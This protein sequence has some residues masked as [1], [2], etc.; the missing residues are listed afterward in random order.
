M[1]TTLSVNIAAWP[2]G[3]SIPA[4]YAF[5]KIPAAGH[6]ELGGNCS[7]AIAW[8]GA[9]DNTRSFAIICHDPD[10]PSVADDVNQEGKT[11][12]SDLPRVDFYHWV[13]VDIPADMA[14]LAEGLASAG[15]TPKGKA[16]GQKD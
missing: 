6:F 4:K 11:V 10:V 3:A 2:E 13:L 9:P 14:A 5:G 1:T 12:P 16:P 8:Q 15:V 7:P